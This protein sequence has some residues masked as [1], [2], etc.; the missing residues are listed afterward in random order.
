MNAV[1]ITTLVLLFGSISVLVSAYFGLPKVLRLIKKKIAINK[2]ENEVVKATTHK[3][4]NSTDPDDLEPYEIICRLSFNTLLIRKMVAQLN[5]TTKKWDFSSAQV[6]ENT[7]YDKRERELKL[8]T[9]GKW[10]G[11]G[12]YEFILFETAGMSFQK[13]IPDAHNTLL[14][15]EACSPIS[16][17]V[18]TSNSSVD[19]EALKVQKKILATQRQIA[20]NSAQSA[21]IAFASKYLDK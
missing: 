14:F 15:S 16:G 4:A 9:A 11:G 18:L 8:T 12:F 2:Y 7:K 13:K 20:A 19:D 3:F 10:V 17:A 6:T 5:T 1:Q 21:S